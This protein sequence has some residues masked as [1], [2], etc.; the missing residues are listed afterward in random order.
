MYSYIILIAK[1]KVIG[2]LKVHSTLTYYYEYPT[3]DWE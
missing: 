2:A 3:I 1:H